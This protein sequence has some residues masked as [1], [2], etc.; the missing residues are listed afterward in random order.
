MA[1]YQYECQNPDCLKVF[2]HMHDWEDPPPPCP[3]C[4]GPTVRAFVPGACSFCCKGEGWTTSAWNRTRTRIP[5]PHEVVD[6]D[7]NDCDAK[8]RPL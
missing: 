3:T 6:K 2:D 7:G 1:I 5:Q 8:G 4:E